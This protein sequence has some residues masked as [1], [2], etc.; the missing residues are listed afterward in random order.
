[1][2]RSLL[3]GTYTGVVVG[4]GVSIVASGIWGTAALPF[5]VGSSIGFAIGS[6]RWYENATTE[7][8]LD[9]HRYPTLLHIH[10]MANFPSKV[11][12][13]CGVH[14]WYS[15]PQ[16]RSSW[17]FKSMLVTAWLSAKPQID[18][19]QSRIEAE[20]ADSYKKEHLLGIG[21]PLD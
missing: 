17:V 4:I 2:F 14:G 8:L 21:P 16:L 20:V 6:I 13:D 1:M 7:A 5:V 15:A 9:F 12:S 3:A 10:L 18:T 19:V 11:T